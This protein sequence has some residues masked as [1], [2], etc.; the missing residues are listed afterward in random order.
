[1]GDCLYQKFLDENIKDLQVVLTTIGVYGLLQNF[2]VWLLYE[3]ER[4]KKGIK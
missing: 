1:M 2:E 4:E 3:L